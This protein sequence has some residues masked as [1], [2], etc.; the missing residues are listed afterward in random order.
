MQP[1]INDINSRGSFPHS[2]WS[3]GPRRARPSLRRSNPPKTE[4][5]APVGERA[6]CLE[7]CED[8]F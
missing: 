1:K 4:A 7:A 6:V 3:R 2:R 8:P 5:D